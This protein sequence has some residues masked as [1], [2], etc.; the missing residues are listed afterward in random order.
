MLVQRWKQAFNQS[1]ENV[2]LPGELQQL[3][4][5]Y[6][7]TK[8]FDNVSSTGDLQQLTSVVLPDWITIA[9]RTFCV[10]L[11]VCWVVVLFVG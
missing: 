2:S 11:L 1:L 8:E 10:V 5:G 9:E 6:V 3:T 7:S 4:F